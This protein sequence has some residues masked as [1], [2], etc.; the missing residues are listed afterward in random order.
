MPGLNSRSEVYQEAIVYLINH[1]ATDAELLALY[2]EAVQQMNEASFISNH[3]YLLKIYYLELEFKNQD[4]SQRQTILLLRKRRERHFL[5]H[6]VYHAVKSTDTHNQERKRILLDQE[7]NQLRLLNMLLERNTSNSAAS[8]NVIDT[9]TDTEWYTEDEGSDSD[10]DTTDSCLELSELKSRARFLCKG[11][12]YN[13]YKEQLREL[14]FRKAKNQ[15]KKSHLEAI[16]AQP[17]VE[18][19]DILDNTKPKWPTL[20]EKTESQPINRWHVLDKTVKPLQHILFSPSRQLCHRFL[21]L[22]RW[23]RPKLKVGYHRIEW[24]CVC[25]NSSILSYTTFYTFRNLNTQ[26]NF[27]NQ[28]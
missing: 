28:S 19:P 23:L 7:E 17:E 9:L 20:P 25:V 8:R 14:V 21:S 10:A 15:A 5:S 18:L 22:K 11:R 24:Q 13:Q 16:Q 6:Q 2:G 12:P 1:F 26:N 4:P 27:A 3:Q